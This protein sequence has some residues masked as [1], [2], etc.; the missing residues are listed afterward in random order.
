MNLDELKLK[1]KELI[2]DDVLSNYHEYRKQELNRRMVEQPS[3]GRQS[4]AERGEI[5]ENNNPKADIDDLLK[6]Y[7]PKQDP[8]D[9]KEGGASDPTHQPA[10]IDKNLKRMKEAATT[11]ENDKEGEDRRP[12]EEERE[13]SERKKEKLRT[14]SESVKQEAQQ[15]EKQNEIDKAQREASELKKRDK[16]LEAE[17]QRQEEANRQREASERNRLNDYQP[18]ANEAFDDASID[19]PDVSGGEKKLQED[20][21]APGIPNIEG[22]G[23]RLGFNQPLRIAESKESLQYSDRGQPL[24][25]KGPNKHAEKEVAGSLED[26]FEYDFDGDD[27][28]A[29]QPVV[30]RDNAQGTQLTKPAREDF[31][32]NFEDEI[33]DDDLE[34]PENHRGIDDLNGRPG[35]SR[36]ASSGKGLDEY[37][38]DF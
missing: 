7:I 13:L 9:Q 32:Y 31:D 24:S 23:T 38:D 30:G 25:Q 19:E 11:K 10:P 36:V 33:L 15:R 20:G 29:K 16:E 3:V 6:K 12:R 35:V 27:I 28:G 1:K 37:L 2:N 21:L 8:S 22:S 34:G 17:R 5:Y 26:D 14:E 4:P 18:I